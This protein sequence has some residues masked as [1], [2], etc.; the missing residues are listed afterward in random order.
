MCT[1]STHV[2]IVETKSGEDNL[3]V[4]LLVIDTLVVLSSR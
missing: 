2:Q 3:L 4:D 1:G